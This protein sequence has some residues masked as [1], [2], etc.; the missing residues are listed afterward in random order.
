[1]ITIRHSEDRGHVNLGWLDSRHSFS[2]GSYFDP[3]QM[4]F[5]HLR[6][7]NEDRVAPKAGFPTHP[8]QDMEILTY[9]IE[10][11]LAHRDSMGNGSVIHRGDIQRMSAGAG[12]THSE[13]NA[14]DDEEVHLL[15]IWLQTERKGLEPDYEQVRY[16]DH[17]VAGGLQVLATRGGADGAVHV[18]QDVTLYRGTLKPDTVIGWVPAQGRHAWLQV[19]CGA[20]MLN[21]K[22]LSSGDGAAVSDIGRLDIHGKENS[23]FLLFDLN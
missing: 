7:I 4:G 12:I 19:I 9:I 6:V 16:A 11:A 2:F 15:Q 21:G 8:H 23:E 17:P 20:L 10:G 14:S 22:E 1:M 5:H 18:N 3:E 13:Y